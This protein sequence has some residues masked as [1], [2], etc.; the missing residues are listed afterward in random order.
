MSAGV[1]L[2]YSASS[3]QISVNTANIATN[4]AAILV[5]QKGIYYGDLTR[6]SDTQLQLAGVTNTPGVAEV[7]GTIVD[8]ATPKTVNISD[9]LAEGGSPS[10]STSYYVYLSSS[11][12]LQLS[13][14]APTALGYRSGDA[15]RRLVG[16]CYIHISNRFLYDQCVC[17][18]KEEKFFEFTLTGDISKNTGS[19]AWVNW[20][21]IFGLAVM[22]GTL[23][24]IDSVCNLKSDNSA[25]NGL[26]CKVKDDLGERFSKLES[27]TN[28]KY[29][30]I[31]IPKIYN[32][33][34]F[35]I[36]TTFVYY[37]YNSGD[38][39]TIEDTSYIQVL[40][41]TP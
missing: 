38:S 30:G 35:S 15:T 28:S 10:V 2:D 8:L 33:S 18:I 24:F 6:A 7:N 4:T 9:N 22:P 34:V 16:Y 17:G 21:T 41:R 19:S 1:G 25:T 13:A 26:A 37:Y 39:Y 14:T 11:G 29:A 32:S 20:D 12:N 3:A 23:V 5:A 40:R 31:S 36:E 27:F